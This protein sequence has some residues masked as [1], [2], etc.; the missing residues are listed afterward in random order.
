VIVKVCDIC[1]KF[2]GSSAVIAIRSAN[3]IAFRK[4]NLDSRGA[5]HLCSDECA[6][7]F[8]SRWLSEDLPET[9]PIL[10]ASPIRQAPS[11]VMAVREP[12]P[13]E[14]AEQNEIMRDLVWN[15]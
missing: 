6:L 7:Q 4:G 13:E 15:R 9:V 8:F 10:T 5:S 14:I 2:L 3:G 1:Q 12:T 11:P